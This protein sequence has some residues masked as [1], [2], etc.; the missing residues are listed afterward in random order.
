MTAKWTDEHSAKILLEEIS[1]SITIN[2]DGRQSYNINLQFEYDGLYSLVNHNYPLDPDVSLKLFQKSVVSLKVKNN[3]STKN[4]L[5]EFSKLC[6]K[7]LLKKIKYRV[8]T[9]V[10]VDKNFPIKPRRLSGCSFR[11][12]KE[13]PKKY[14]SHRDS[15]IDGYT[16]PNLK[17]N[18]EFLK[19]VISVESPDVQS[20]FKKSLEAFDLLRA[21]WQI[22]FKSSWNFLGESNET[23]FGVHSIFRIGRIHTIHEVDG[24]AATKMF[25]YEHEN[26]FNFVSKLKDVKEA[27]AKFDENLSEFRKSRFKEHAEEILIGFIRALDSVEYEYKFLRLW[28]TLETG[29]KSDD[30][31]VI[32]KRLSFYYEDW[33]VKKALLLSLRQARNQ[34]THKGKTPENIGLKCYLLQDFVLVLIRY[35]MNNA[36][37]YKTI[38]EALDFI[39]LPGS[40]SD[41]KKRISILENAIKFRQK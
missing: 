4:L 18:E 11:F 27:E 25:W 20:A 37:K 29:V 2:D 30:T 16:G 22:G 13:V 32:V 26:H 31:K 3:L 10:S 14:L 8:I 34:H 28:S 33:E 7:Y 39:S 5:V 19:V 9:S 41:L 15:V 21:I 23:K 38:D 24:S 6:L 1:S 12:Y 40:V 35:F 17:E 36:F